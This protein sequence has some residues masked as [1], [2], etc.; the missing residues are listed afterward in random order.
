M[1]LI[2]FVLLPFGGCG[3]QDLEQSES[4]AKKNK[5]MAKKENKPVQSADL[6]QKVGSDD[7]YSRFDAIDELHSRMLD[8]QK[9]GTQER[10]ASRS[11]TGDIMDNSEKRNLIEKL[12]VVVDPHNIVEGSEEATLDRLSKQKA[13]ELLRVL[14]AE[15]QLP[16]ESNLSDSA[17][18]VAL[19]KWHSE[20]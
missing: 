19:L 2:V 15:L 16:I 3:S 12:V 13:I 6:V 17:F 8:P 11:M 20:Q 7:V 14:A 10:G 1:I 9:Q 5:I 4:G 18:S